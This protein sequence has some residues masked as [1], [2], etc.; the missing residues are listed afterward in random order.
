MYEKSEELVKK[1]FS[2][3]LDKGGYPYL[4]HLYEVSNN[5]TS[6]DAKI[7]GL[8]HDVLE[9]TETTREDLLE[10]G[11]SEFTVSTIE[12]L[13]RGAKEDYDDYIERIIKSNNKIA[14]E[15]C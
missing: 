3:K 7:V 5:V 10:M 13:T 14:L 2:G 9:D 6:E 8:L 11:Y 15:T 1:L 4:D 12:I